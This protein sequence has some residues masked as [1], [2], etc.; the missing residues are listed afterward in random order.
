[1][2]PG[3]LSAVCVLCAICPGRAADPVK[4]PPEEFV[5]RLRTVGEYGFVGNPLDITYRPANE[6]KPEHRLPAL[7]V[8]KITPELVE[9]L[10]ECP[11]PFGLKISLHGQCTDEDLKRLSGIANL[12][13]LDLNACTWVTGKTGAVLAEFKGLRTIQMQGS[14]LDDEGAEA[15]SRLEALEELDLAAGRVTDKGCKSLAKLKNLTLL[16]VAQ[17]KM[18][19]EGV[20]D[21]ARCTNLRSLALI[22][23]PV[24]NEGLKHLAPLKKLERLYLGFTKV[25]NKG[26][27]EMPDFAELRYINLA[28]TSAAY[29]G[30]SSLKRFKKLERVGVWGLGLFPSELEAVQKAMPKVI[31]EK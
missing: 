30:L 19:D 4:E 15:L 31:I 9:T 14:R 11:V 12:R 23:M 24:T 20:K 1:M 13:H 3:I 18:T 26:I 6:K 7:H 27:I 16:S 2:K 22:S 17:N 29:T 8:W 28:A 25:T 21:L 5:K 10:K